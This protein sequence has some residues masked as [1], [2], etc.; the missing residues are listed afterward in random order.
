MDGLGGILWDGCL[1]L[2]RWITEFDTLSF[3]G[4]KVLELGSG[5]G[6]AGLV[7]SKCGARDVLVTDREIDLVSFNLERHFPNNVR[8]GKI[9]WGENMA[10][11][12]ET[13]DVVIG[14][15]LTPMMEGHRGLSEEYRACIEEGGK[16]LITV[17]IEVRRVEEAAMRISL[18]S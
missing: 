1:S 7:A 15:E 10:E 6:M 5:T 11:G 3:R 9:V 16:G 2:C 8:V 14:A 18:R 4:A 13:F 12:R 17:D